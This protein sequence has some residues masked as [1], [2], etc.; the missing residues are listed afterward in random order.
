MYVCIITE[1]QKRG[2]PY[3]FPMWGSSP[4]ARDLR[5]L[6]LYFYDSYSSLPN[7]RAESNNCPT[8]GISTKT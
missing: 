2:T 4:Y 1:I 5:G 7:K 3:F 6:P 8:N